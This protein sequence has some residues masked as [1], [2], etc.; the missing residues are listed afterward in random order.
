MTRAGGLRVSGLRA[1]VL[2][3]SSVP[4]LILAA[5]AQDWIPSGSARVLGWHDEEIGGLRSCVAYL[6]VANTGSVRIERSSLS[7]R[8][9]TASRSYF[10]TLVLE[11]ALP[12]GGL[13]YAELSVAY[14]DPGESAE[15]D[16]GV[17]LVSVYFE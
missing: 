9:F 15:A 17:E 11:T 14:A 12:P 13:V 7:L 2:L 3:A 16:G 4:V 5:C 6:E 8:V 1:A 10:R